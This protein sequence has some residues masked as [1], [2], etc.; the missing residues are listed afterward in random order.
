MGGI[1]QETLVLVD[2]QDRAVGQAEKLKV[3]QAGQL[4]RA[5]SVFI[6]RRHNG[7]EELLLQQRNRNKY[8]CGNLWTN[9]CCGHPR[10]G[11]EVLAAANRR[12]YEEMLIHSKLVFIGSFQYYARCDNALIEHEL[13]HVFIGSYQQEILQVN[14]QEVQ[15]FRWN[16]ITE[17]AQELLDFPQQFTP[18]FS[19]ALMIVKNHQKQITQL[20]T[21][22]NKIEGEN[23]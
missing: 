12:L 16:T 11:E 23:D 5:F 9:S 13:D 2:D 8:H 15:A 14:P 7:R 3:H 17:I 6:F 4:H 19:K 21:N 22:C 18:W 20:L 10:V 1:L